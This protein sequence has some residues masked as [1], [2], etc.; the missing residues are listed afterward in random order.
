MM[1]IRFPSA[2][3][4][5]FVS[6]G[7][8]GH[9]GHRP[10]EGRGKKPGYSVK[11][12]IGSAM[13]WDAEERECSN[14]TWKSSNRRAATQESPW[15]YV[16]CRPRIQADPDL[17]RDDEHRTAAGPGRLRGQPD[18]D[19]RRG[20]NEGGHRPRRGLFASDPER[21]F[22]PQQFKNPA[23]P[24][25]HEKTTGP[26]IWSDTVGGSMSWSPVSGPEARSRVSPGTSKRR[27]V[28]RFSPWPWSP[29][30]AP[31]SVRA[32][33]AGTEARS[34]QDPGDRRRFCPRQPGPFPRRQ[35]GAGGQRRGHRVC[36]APR[37][38]GRD[39]LRN[40]LRR[41]RCRGPTA[42]RRRRNAGAR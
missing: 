34:A 1:T 15:A 38:G 25:I 19:A 42:W 33:R 8:R 6:T 11:C 28:K 10:G 40:L 17:A 18:P 2:I 14:P 36:P 26:E 22:L 16:A 24:A 4:P 31:S 27:C 13:I 20:G 5:S 7:S 30:R 23:N 41:R 9:G 21:Y 35:G 3:P 32:C 12:R 39:H 29:R 37:P